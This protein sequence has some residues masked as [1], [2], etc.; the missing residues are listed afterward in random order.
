MIPQKRTI[1]LEHRQEV[2]SPTDSGKKVVQK[3]LKSPVD[4]EKKVEEGGPLKKKR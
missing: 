2:N 1:E 4:S 3:M